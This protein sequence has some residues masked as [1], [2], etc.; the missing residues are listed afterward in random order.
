MFLQS[1]RASLEAPG[2]AEAQEHQEQ[3][4]YAFTKWQ[5]LEAT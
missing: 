2:D 4:D 3:L 1:L 5:R